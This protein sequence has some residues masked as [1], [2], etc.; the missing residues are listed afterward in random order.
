MALLPGRAT[1]IAVLAAAAAA[2]AGC[3]PGR[4]SAQPALSEASCRGIKDPSAH[5]YR[6]RVPENRSRADGR[7]IDLRIVVIPAADAA[8]RADDAVVV[9]AG[10]PGQAATDFLGR[11]AAGANTRRDHIYA[12]QRGTGGSNGLVCRFYGPPSD[13]PS[14]FTG[15]LPL[16]KVRACRRDLERQSDLAQYTTAA[17]V[18]DLEAIRVAL[19]YPRL[20]LRG[21]SYGTR[22]AMEYVRRH[23]ERVRTVTLEGP[24]TPVMAA[25]DRFG[26]LAQRALD[27]LIAECAADHSCAG[28]YPGLRE[29]AAE[30]FARLRRAPVGVLAAH[31]DR[32]GETQPV[33]LTRDHAGEVIRYMLYTSGDASAIPYVLHHAYRG[34]FQPIASFLMRWRRGGTFDGLYISI[35]CAEDVPRVAADAGA[36][37]EPTFLGGY[38]VREQTAACAEWPKGAAPADAATAVTASVPALIVSGMLDPVTPPANG[39]ELARTLTNSLHVQVP[40]GGHGFAGLEGLACLDA[41][42]DRFIDGATV[43]GLDTSCIR[44]IRR[45]GFVIGR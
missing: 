30:V 17:S 6:L 43:A 9:L 45:P 35:T 26:E 5:C 28:A 18:A 39:D 25:P 11:A 19:G 8:N 33:T 21:G 41:I 14:Y 42:H 15:F 36:R 40:S 20:N 13:V 27:G 4:L 12:D 34:N 23:P 29:E 16:D 7:T 2:I 32:P 1:L 24:V 3:D 38:R 10:G 37:A 31:P 22:L 44:S